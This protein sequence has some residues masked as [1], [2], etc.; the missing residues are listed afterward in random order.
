MPKYRVI[1][2]NV[3]HYE[4]VI[5]RDNEE[6]VDDEV[7]CWERED[8]ESNAIPEDSYGTWEYDIIEE[9]ENK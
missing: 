5:E 7:G 4:I 6:S 8:F 3:V 1:A 2:T 9:E